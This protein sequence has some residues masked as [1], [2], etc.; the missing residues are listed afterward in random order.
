MYWFGSV[1]LVGSWFFISVT[2]RVRKSLAEMDAFGSP[3]LEELPDPLVAASMARGSASGLP[4]AARW[5]QMVEVAIEFSFCFWCSS[6]GGW[7]HAMT[8]IWVPRPLWAVALAMDAMAPRG[9]WLRVST[10]RLPGMP[11]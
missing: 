9:V 4:C 2:R 8:E 11:T 5:F 3:V 6:V 10:S 7:G 1:A